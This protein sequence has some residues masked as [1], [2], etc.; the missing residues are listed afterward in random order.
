MPI[1]EHSHWQNGGRDWLDFFTFRS[2]PMTMQADM[3][4]K[5]QSGGINYI[6]ATLCVGVITKYCVPLFPSQPVVLMG[7]VCEK[8]QHA[9]VRFASCAVAV[10]FCVSCRGAVHWCC[11]RGNCWLRVG[12]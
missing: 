1:F 11:L 5:E 10:P 12:C 7:D 4:E 2:L 3:R 9:C 8:V 6:L